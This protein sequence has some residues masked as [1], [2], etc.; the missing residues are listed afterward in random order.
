MKAADLMGKKAGNNIISSHSAGEVIILYK[1]AKAA[2]L[3][4]PGGSGT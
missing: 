4:E 3:M 1:E 2:S